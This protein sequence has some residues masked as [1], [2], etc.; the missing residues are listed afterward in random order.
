[1]AAVAAL[2][3]QYEADFRPNMSIVV[4]ALQPLLNTRAGPTGESG[5]TW[6]MEGWVE[7]LVNHENI[8]RVNSLVWLFFVMIIYMRVHI[9]M[10]YFHCFSLSTCILSLYY[11]DF[12]FSVFDT[13]QR[14]LPVESLCLG[15]F[16]Y[17]LS[18]GGLWVNY[19]TMEF[20]CNNMWKGKNP[21]PIWKDAKYWP[22]K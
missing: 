1:M 20:L 13:L 10:Y 5:L 12:K 21:A 2:C 18:F 17:K 22:P 14:F 7:E 8:Q 16:S 15:R 4:K 6:K 9:G 11:N 3:V 19:E